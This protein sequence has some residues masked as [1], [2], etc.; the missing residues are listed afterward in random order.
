M[1]ALVWL[2]GLTSLGVFGYLLI[3][4]FKPERLQ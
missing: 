2:A 3:A 1:T 4:L